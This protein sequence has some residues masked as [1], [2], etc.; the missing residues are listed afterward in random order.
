MV[1]ED[2]PSS[3]R[4][5]SGLLRAAG[6]RVA[7]STSGEAALDA[8]RAAPP[9]LILM[10]MQLPGM[11]GLEVARALRADPDTNGIPVVA[12]TAHAMQGDAERARAA[13]CCGYITKPIES[14]RFTAQI[15]EIL[16]NSAAGP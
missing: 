1:V 13:G 16:R 8:A 10:D 4:L 5:F 11:D 6:Y 14:A 2:N 3:M 9:R 7:E 15:A 12:L